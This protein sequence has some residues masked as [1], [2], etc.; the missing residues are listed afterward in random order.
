MT[1]TPAIIGQIVT[2]SPGFPGGL[3]GP[4]QAQ[5]AAVNASSCGYRPGGPFLPSH[6]PFEGLVLTFLASSNTFVIFKG[7][8]S[9]FLENPF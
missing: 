8:R 4:C 7:T 3:A 2:E 6:L 1:L 9:F 5:G